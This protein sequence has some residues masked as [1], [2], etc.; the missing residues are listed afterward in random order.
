MIKGI[1]LAIV[2]GPPIVAAV[3]VIVQDHFE[4]KGFESPM[5]KEHILMNSVEYMGLH[6][7]DQERKGSRVR[8]SK[9]NGII[10]DEMNSRDQCSGQ[11]LVVRE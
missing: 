9:S 3:I 2:I 10:H 11:N 4:P 5:L 7:W 1:I 6:Y 8:V